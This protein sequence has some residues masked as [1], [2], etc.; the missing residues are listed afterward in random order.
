MYEAETLL[1]EGKWVEKRMNDFMMGR[2]LR[3]K[4]LGIVGIHL[5]LSHPLSPLVCSLFTILYSSMDS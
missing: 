1:R 5:S 3:G 4:K 2:E